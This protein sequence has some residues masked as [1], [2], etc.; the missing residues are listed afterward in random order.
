MATARG[1]R[2]R[3]RVPGEP[4]LELHHR[5]QP[6]HRRRADQGRAALS[7]DTGFSA[8]YARLVAMIGGAMILLRRQD[9]PAPPAPALGTAPAIP[10]ARPQRIPTL[11]M[12]TARGWAAGQT[13][14]A[15]PG[16]AVNAFATGLKH[17]R[18]IQVL[19]NGDVLAAE[20]LTLAGP[21]RTPFDYAIVDARCGAPRRSGTSPNRITLLR[22]AD[23]DG[24]AEMRESFLDGLNQPF[25]MALVGDTFYVGNTDGVVAFPY[26]TGATR[27]TAPGRR[28]GDFKPGGHWTRSLLAS[29][30]GR[31]ALRRRRLAQQHR[32]ERAWRP[33]RA[34]RR[35]TSIDL[36]T[37]RRRIF[38]S[39]LRNPVGLAWEPTHRRALDRGQRARRP[40][41]R[42]PARLPDLGPRRRLLRLALLLLGPDRGRPRAAGPGDG[43][44][45]AEARLRARR[46]YRLARPLLAAGRHAAGL[47]RR[48][49]DRPARLVEPQHA[50]RLQGRL[51][52]RSRTAAPPVRRATS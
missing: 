45:G 43:R 35:S 41:R 25:G 28:V 34:G 50:E 32:R 4:R 10:E 5:H 49:G 17:P 38:A 11:K 51:R 40:R 26:P 31:Q 27:I 20:A 15:A 23:G 6:R 36:E 12:P 48:H 42:D 21:V 39:G 33:R 22:D 8:A 1:D 37:A 9:G 2:P 30:D 46:A 16:L 29:P 13:P 19:P 3:R 14:T 47:P 44:E 24:V 7:G 18:W 52:A